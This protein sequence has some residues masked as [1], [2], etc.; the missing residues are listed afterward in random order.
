MRSGAR[1]GADVG[2]A[3]VAGRSPTVRPTRSRS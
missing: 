3:V 1:G 2:A